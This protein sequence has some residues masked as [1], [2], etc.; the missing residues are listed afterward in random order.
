MKFLARA[1][2]LFGDGVKAFHLNDTRAKLGSHLESHEHWGSG[3]L[4][5]EGVRALLARPEYTQAV[6]ILET[7]KEPGADARNLAWLRP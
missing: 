4:G 7:P 6:G 5:K 1:H 3:F 2:R